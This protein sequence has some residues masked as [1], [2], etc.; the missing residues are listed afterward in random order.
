MDEWIKGLEFLTETGQKCND[1]RQ[2]FV[3][4]SDTLG[5]TS[6]IDLL[7]PHTPSSTPPLDNNDHDPQPQRTEVPPALVDPGSP[8]RKNGE[9]IADLSPFSAR[10][11]TFVKGS[12]KSVTGEQIKGAVVNVWQCAKVPS[13]TE[14]GGSPP[15]SPSGNSG[16][17]RSQTQNTNVPVAAANTCADLRASYETEE[18]G[19][20]WF[21]TV[22]P[23]AYKVPSDGPVG[24]LLNGYLGKH[25]YCPAR[26]QLTVAAEGY[27]TLTTNIFDADSNY[28]TSDVVF[29]VRPNLIAHWNPTSPTSPSSTTT[30]STIAKYTVQFDITLT[31]V[32]QPDATDNAFLGIEYQ[33][34]ENPHPNWR[35]GMAQFAPW[36]AIGDPFGQWVG[37]DPNNM[38]G[39]A[40]SL[41]ISAVVPR[42]IGFVASV[43]EDGS[44][45]LSPFSYFNIVAHNPPM[46][47]LGICRKPDGSKKDTMLN[48]EQTKEWTVNII[49][50]W[51][52]EAANHTC[53]NFAR[54]VNEMKESGLHAIPSV[55]VKPPRVSEAGVQMECVLK[56]LYEVDD[57]KTGKPSS[58]VVLGEVV[59][60]HVHEKLLGST[61]TGKPVV[62]LEGYR[63]VSRLG[64]NSYSTL[65]RVF[66][67]ARP[68]VS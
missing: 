19:S 23:C 4:L 39:G 47:V 59:R 52:V 65:G 62:K 66:D 64:G 49:S 67:L 28:L 63:P 40:Y 15:A 50:E 14:T 31:P 61:P 46:V 11:L 26:I 44:H 35:P 13:S 34:T 24:R 27:H 8:L 6:L 37:F 5:A 58:C 41:C 43:G 45:N 22:R 36:S 1:I 68:V 53:G 56:Q 12:V 55:N 3:L 25:M 16:L 2:E 30:D 18:D 48:I 38:E 51:F 60:F 17:M 42:P 33:T 9:P 7:H 20:Y 10:D 21:N 54:G 32:S 29:G 57:N